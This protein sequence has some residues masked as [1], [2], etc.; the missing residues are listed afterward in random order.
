MPCSQRPST[1]CSGVSLSKSFKGIHW[2]FLVSLR[3]S[4][5]SLA[6]IMG[7]AGVIDGDF[8]ETPI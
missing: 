2:T 1:H 7:R 8:M 4:V 6:V 3:W 5:I